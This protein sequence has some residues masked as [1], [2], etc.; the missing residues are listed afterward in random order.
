MADLRVS[1]PDS[2]DSGELA[3]LFE[4]LSLD[5]DVSQAAVLSLEPAASR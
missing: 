3:A 5:P 4:W 2:T 1:V